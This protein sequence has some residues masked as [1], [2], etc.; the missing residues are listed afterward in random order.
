MKDLAELEHFRDP[1]YSFDD[2]GLFWLPSPVD[3]APLKVIASN[4]MSWD[5]VSVSRRNR[6]PNWLEMDFVKRW[7]F[8][9]DE[10]AM[11]L[12]VPEAEHINYHPYCLHLW[13]PQRQE[14]PRPPGEMVA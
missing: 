13:R 6:C 9:P 12:H 14:I 8:R 11:Q 3:R 1:A 7:F 10:C 4:G 2:G 5:H